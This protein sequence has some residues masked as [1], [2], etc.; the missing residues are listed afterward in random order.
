MATITRGHN[1]LPN[2]MVTAA[3]LHQLVESATVADLTSDNFQ[4]EIHGLVTATPASLRTGDFLYLQEAS[5]TIDRPQ[6]YAAWTEPTYLI[7]YFRGWAS[8]FANARM[9]SSR[10]FLSGD[11]GEGERLEEAGA[12]AHEILSG[13][14]SVTLMAGLNATANSKTFTIGSSRATVVQAAAAP[15]NIRATTLGLGTARLPSNSAASCWLDVFWED[16]TKAWTRSGVTDISGFNGF[17]LAKGAAVGDG[18]SL[19]RQPA[20]FLGSLNFRE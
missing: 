19:R 7:R 6:N 17:R 20:Y 5:P 12:M 11:Y 8:V 4:G 14:G 9:E 16:G 13:S 10:W 15:I 18:G 1:F 2:D 3:K